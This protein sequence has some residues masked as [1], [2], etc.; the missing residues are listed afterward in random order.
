MLEL[1]AGL[2][3]CGFVA[4]LL[5]VEARETLGRRDRPVRTAHAL[6]STDFD[7]NDQERWNVTVNRIRK[8]WVPN[9]DSRRV[10]F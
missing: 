10:G 7:Q 1:G 8:T 3:V 5:G 2:A 9:W 6:E 4:A